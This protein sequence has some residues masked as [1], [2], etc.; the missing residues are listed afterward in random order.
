[1]LLVGGSVGGGPRAFYSRRL[2]QVKRDLVVEPI[3]LPEEGIP[4]PMDLAKTFGNDRPV[5]LEIGCGKGTF[6]TREAMRRPD[7]NFL[8]VE[9]ARFYWRYTCDR[10]RRNGCE[11]NARM[12]RYDAGVFVRDHLADASISMV[13]I[14]FPDPW[15]KARHNRRRLIQPPFLE[16]V[17]RI[18]VPGGRVNAVTDHADY[19]EQI[20]RV[21]KEGPMQVVPYEPPTD[22]E[23]GEFVGTN[24]ERKYIIEGRTFNA[25]SAVK[26]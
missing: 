11:A 17:E 1:M 24:F 8:G 3:A 4:E 14:Y 26:A 22:I 12:L 15:P 18:L 5:E 16:E 20:D 21:F 13:H 6:I 2:M 10:L 9:W 23:G 19:W 25:T 7:V